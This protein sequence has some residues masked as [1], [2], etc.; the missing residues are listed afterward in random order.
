MIFH[1][2]C[3]IFL[4]FFVFNQIIQNNAKTM[5]TIEEFNAYQYGKEEFTLAV[6]G[7]SGSN[8]EAKKVLQLSSFDA[9][10]H[11]GDFDY[12]CLADYY[13]N[14]IL[15]SKRKYQFMGVLGNHDA[16]HTCPTEVAKKFLNNVYEEMTNNKNREVQCEFSDSKFMWAC[17]YKN[18]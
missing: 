1:I 15:D 6:I 10:L 18:M 3:Y 17:V 7:D 8:N 2:E 14:N 9:L 13:F 16:Q 12:K 5:I 4:I 11:L